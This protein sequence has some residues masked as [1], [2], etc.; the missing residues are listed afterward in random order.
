MVSVGLLTKGERGDILLGTS[1]ASAVRDS[2]KN[3]LSTVAIT[4]L[5][6]EQDEKRKGLKSALQG[7][8]KPLTDY[9]FIT[10]V[11]RKRLLRISTRVRTVEAGPESA[12][13]I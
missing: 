4:R 5:S 7:L 13:R 10:F 6:A 12:S 3:V 1:F 9:A 8:F 2:T 11:L